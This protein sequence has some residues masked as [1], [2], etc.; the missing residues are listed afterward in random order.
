[1]GWLFGTDGVRGVANDGLT[2]ELAFRL[3]RCGAAVLAANGEAD[4]R[5]SPVIL[6]RDTRRSG[7][8]LEAALAAGVASA[9]LDVLRVGVV[10]TPG[11]AYLT[12]TLGAAFGVMISASHNPAE[13]NGIKFFTADGFKLPDEVETRIEDLMGGPGRLS[14]DPADG[15]PRPVAAGVGRIYSGEEQARA[16]AR[17]LE[18]AAG[19]SLAGLRLVVDCAHGAA[20]RL[21]PQVLRR[22]GAD[23]I[24]LCDAPDGMNINVGCGSTSPEEMQ[25]AVKRFGADAGLAYDGDGD[26]VI[27]AD[28]QGGLVDGDAILAICARHLAAQ[29]RLRNRAVAA[30]VYSN[31]GLKRTLE[32]AGVAVVE[33][34]PGDRYVLEAM[35]ARDLVLGGEQSG[36]VIF[37]EHNTTGD[38]LLTALQ[39]LRVMRETGQP[40]S[41]LAAQMPRVPQILTKVAVRDKGAFAHNSRI[42]EVIQEEQAQLGAEGRLL[43][44]PSGT[45]PVIRIMGE[46]LDSARIRSAVDRIASV[47]EAELG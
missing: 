11:V 22:L 29:G 12:R 7:D 38:G 33:T 2:P 45:E 27:M 30:T 20:Y 39:V 35:L 23:V 36:H 8:L 5:G 43:V 40:L 46:G 16:Y 37:L 32:A 24:T 14:F 44:R 9:G 28:E 31:L 47:V 42:Q 26:R 18:E 19:V 4:R 15:L 1:M 34:A 25:G 6:G 10:P 13:D 17:L 3:G 41:K 21:A